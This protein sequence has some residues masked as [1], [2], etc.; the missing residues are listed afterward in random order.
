M[1][2]I[3]A[4]PVR[5]NSSLGYYTNYVNLLDLLRGGDSRRL[6]A[7]RPAVGQLRSSYAGI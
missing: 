6:F 1:A 4:E 2:E 5:L 7:Q 3:E